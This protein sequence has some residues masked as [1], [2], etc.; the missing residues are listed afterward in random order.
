MKRHL[1]F[2]SNEN[3]SDHVNLLLPVLEDGGH[4]ERHCHQKQFVIPSWS[5]RQPQAPRLNICVCVC[6]CQLMESVLAASHLGCMD[7]CEGEDSQ[8]CETVL[9]LQSCC[10]A[11]KKS[12][13]C[14]L[15]PFLDGVPRRL[16]GFRGALSSSGTCTFGQVF[17]S[18]DNLCHQSAQ[19]SCLWAGG[20]RMKGPWSGA[21]WAGEPAAA[22]LNSLRILRT[23]SE[24]CLK[25]RHV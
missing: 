19:S 16:M 23:L 11:S 10:S 14:Q 15:L 5:P 9:V 1:C 8:L 20:W 18:P 2:M 3:V 22:S 21:V 7:P 12:S 25:V 24:N 4:K 13:S 6:V 17:V